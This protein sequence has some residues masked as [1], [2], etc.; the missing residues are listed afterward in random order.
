MCLGC[1][2]EHGSPAIFTEKTRHAAELVQAIY[3]W[4]GVGGNAHVVVDD[5]NLDDENIDYCLNKGLEANVHEA[6]E[7]QLAVERAALLA[8]KELT[9]DERHSALAI[10][11]GA[12]V[13]L[14]GTNEGTVVDWAKGRP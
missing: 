8:L 9:L 7:E 11:E 14:I 3:D 4:S 12:I 2:H 10:S 5:W 6:G 1:W 13:P